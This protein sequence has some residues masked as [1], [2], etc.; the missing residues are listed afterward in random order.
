MIISNYILAYERLNI[1]QSI[2]LFINKSNI[3]YF[4]YI[5]EISSHTKNAETFPLILMKVSDIS[6]RFNLSLLH[7]T[8]TIFYNLKG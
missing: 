7:S 2:T 4:P 3:T 6:K 8:F 1:F 5:M